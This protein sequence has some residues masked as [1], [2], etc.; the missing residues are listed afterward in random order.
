MGRSLS[1]MLLPQVE[2]EVYSWNSG[3]HVSNKM[4]SLPNPWTIRIYEFASQFLIHQP[5]SITMC[6]HYHRHGLSR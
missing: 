2:L 1:L 5:L 6:Y 4:L 3:V